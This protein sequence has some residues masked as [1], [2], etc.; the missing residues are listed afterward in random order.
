[1]ID[2]MGDKFPGK[3]EMR[4]AS[5]GESIEFRIGAHEQEEFLD[6]LSDC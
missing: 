3:G 4:Y 1:M 2:D 6:Q 5:W